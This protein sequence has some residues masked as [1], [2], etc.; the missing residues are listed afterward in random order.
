MREENMNSKIKG[1][2]SGEIES[3]REKYGANSLK[4]EKTKSY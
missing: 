3:L 1:L 2:S 4:K